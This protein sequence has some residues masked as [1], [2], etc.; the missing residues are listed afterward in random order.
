MSEQINSKYAPEWED[1]Y[2]RIFNAILSRDIPVLLRESSPEF[3]FLEIKDKIIAIT[4]QVKTISQVYDFWLQLP[5][6]K[7]EELTSTLNDM[8]KQ[9][10]I[11]EQFDPKQGDAWNSRNQI[12]QNF[13]SRYNDFYN[14][15]TTPFDGYLGRKAYSKE[16]TSEFGKQAKQELDE[17]KRV[18][19]EIENTQKIVNEAAS[20]ASNTASAAYSVS[21][22]SQAAYHKKI[23]SN[24]LIAT[25]FIMVIAMVIT[26]VVVLDIIQQIGDINAS[27]NPEASILKAVVLT[28]LYLGIR[29]T[30][31]NYSAHQH[32]YIINIQRSNVLQSMDAFRSNA[33]DE[34]TKD[35]VLLA[36]VGAAYSQQET[37]FITTKEGAGADSN[38]IMDVINGLLKKK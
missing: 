29:F 11:M 7:R 12:I 8:V 36:A 18:K 9:F 35:A 15:I 4:G 37:G 16:L 38:N 26:I 2:I 30:S 14:Q 1:T 23:A 5:Q 32:Q 20:I 10:D 27:S 28:F 33:S 34:P 6:R 22:G 13:I 31:K 24:W 21:F 17:I 19:K 25:I 3:N